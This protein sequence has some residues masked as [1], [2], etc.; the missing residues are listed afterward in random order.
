MSLTKQVLQ[1]R[2][3][4][5]RIG[6]KIRPIT[7]SAGKVN[8]NATQG[9]LVGLAAAAAAYPSL[10]KRVDGDSFKAIGSYGL[11]AGILAVAFPKGTYKVARHVGRVMYRTRKSFQAAS[12]AG[13]S[14]WKAMPF[15]KVKVPHG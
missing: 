3:V 15:G 12:Q 7:L 6:G 5:R 9:K 10:R 11:A 2:V 14:Q 8:I 13:S 1:A 4:F